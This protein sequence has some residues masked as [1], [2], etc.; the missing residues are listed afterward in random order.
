M[1]TNSKIPEHLHSL[2]ALRGVAALAVVVFHYS[3]FFT[4]GNA[5]PTSFNVRAEPFY[6]VA[7]LIYKSGWLAVDLFFTLSGF[8]FFWLYSARVSDRS[9]TAGKFF[10]LRFS[11]L[12]PLHLLTLLIVVAGQSIYAWMHPNSPSFVT[13]FDSVRYFV[14]QLGFASMWWPGSEITFNTPA[15]SVSIEV[16]LY[17]AFFL[18]CRFTSPP[19]SRRS[20]M[21]RRRSSRV[22]M[23]GSCAHQA[24]SAGHTALAELRPYYG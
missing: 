11:R 22:P 17:V 8:V 10:L 21:F 5:L 18:F 19:P 1:Q 7:P 20:S 24:S 15:W 12:Y 23:R 13:A 9:I 2:D 6:N 16:L 14:L 4:V 3:N